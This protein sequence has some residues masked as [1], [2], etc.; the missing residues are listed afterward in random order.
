MHN[1]LLNNA[2]LLKI[3]TIFFMQT[4]VAVR[5]MDKTLSVVS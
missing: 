4:D 5:E 1:S 2:I 3:C